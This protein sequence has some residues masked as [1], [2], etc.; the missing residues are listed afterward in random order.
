M[1]KLTSTA[2]LLLCQHVSSWGLSVL[3]TCTSKCRISWHGSDHK[4]ALWSLKLPA[5]PETLMMQ[6][7]SDKLSNTSLISRIFLITTLNISLFQMWLYSHCP[8][9]S[10][11]HRRPPGWCTLWRHR[12]LGRRMM[13]ARR[14]RCTLLPR[15]SW[16]T[17]RRD[18]FL[19]RD[20][21]V[22]LR[23]HNIHPAIPIIKFLKPSGAHQSRY[24]GEQR[25]PPPP[26]FSCWVHWELCAWSTPHQSPED[27]AALHSPEKQGHQ[28]I[29]RPSWT[30]SVV[31]I[32][33]P[34]NWTLSYVNLSVF[35]DSTW[36]LVF[37]F[38]CSSSPSM[39]MLR[40]GYI[41][42]KCSA[43]IRNLWEGESVFVKV[44]VYPC[45]ST[46]NST[47]FTT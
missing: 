3:L 39:S 19:N 12:T 42:R 31:K 16:R 40:F 33:R 24:P 36:W 20:I 43:N 38:S 10:G 2:A 4:S 9:L 28:H 34:S 18:K 26:G 35:L 25:W 46:Y 21:S 17:S 5:T 23:R 45:V 22:N 15:C 6:L 47:F 13:E 29:F 14:G 32:S 8:A 30:E 11:K 27:A 7:R 41:V 37:T 44:C 1:W